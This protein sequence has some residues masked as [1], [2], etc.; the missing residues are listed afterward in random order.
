MQRSL[1]HH[2][3]VVIAAL[4]LLGLAWTASAAQAADTKFQATATF[5]MDFE[6]THGNKFFF[7]AEGNAGPGG[8]FDSTGYGHANFSDYSEWMVVTLDFGQGN[9]LTL[10]IEDDLI[11]FDPL[12]RTGSYVITAGT[13]RFAAASGSGTFTGNPKGDGSGTGVFYLDGTLSW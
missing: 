9:T 10:F 13:G 11:S 7:T 5:Q 12:Q 3:I 1:S 6:A 4:A 2:R 8:P